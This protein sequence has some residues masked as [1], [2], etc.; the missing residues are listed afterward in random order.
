MKRLPRGSRF[1]AWLALLGLLLQVGLG[2]THSARHFDHLVGPLGAADPALAAGELPG[3]PVAPSPDGPTPP[4][5][6]HCAIGLGL[7]AAANIVLADP[8][9]TPLRPDFEVAR[10]EAAS[11]AVALALRRHSLPLARA[12]PVIRIPA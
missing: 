7:A 3:G 11:P 10:L 12:P 5:L 2:A 4:G 8:A 6:D 9:P 1:G